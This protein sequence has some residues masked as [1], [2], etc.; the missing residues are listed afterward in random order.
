MSHPAASRRILGILPTTALAALWM[1][2]TVA[3]F[4]AMAIS[5][6]ELSDTLH[7]FEILTLRSI[8][9][10][11][12]VYLVV[13]LSR[14]GTLRSRQPRWQLR[15]NLLHFFGQAGWTYGLSV[16]PLAVVFTLEFTVPAWTALLAVLFLGERFSRSR[17]VS[18]AGGIIG[19]LVILRPDTAMPDAAALVVLGAAVAY[20]GA[21]TM[22]KQLTRTDGALAILFWMSAIQLPLG[23]GA[24]A[25]FGT[26]VMPTTGDLPWVLMVG[27]AA[28]SAHFCMTRAL[29]LADATIVMPLDFIRLPLIVLV[30]WAFYGEALRLEVAIGAS[31]I[32]VSLLYALRRER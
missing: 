28:L 16:L 21:H 12:V 9:G 31:V 4:M 10:L 23:L 29:R 11:I 2:G 1:C 20:A 7:T 6:R 15:R 27:L 25:A 8:I 32:I 18:V 14:E 17:G 24:N 26:W 22:T 5:V 13:T 3:S 19:V 30:G